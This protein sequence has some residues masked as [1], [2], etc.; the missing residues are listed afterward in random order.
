MLS[1]LIL[2][3]CTLQ[4]ANE[5]LVIVNPN[6][7]VRKGERDWPKISCMLDRFGFSFSSVITDYPGHAIEVVRKKIGQGYRKIMVVG[8]DGTLNE[9]INGI[10]SQSMVPSLAVTVAMITVGTGNDWAR[11]Y[12]IPRSYKHAIRTISR[13]KTFV[14]D[15]GKVSY[16]SRDG[17]VNRFFANLAGMGFDAQ[18]ARRT[19]MKK[20]KGKGGPMSYMINLF[21]SLLQYRSR[22]IT[23]DIDGSIIKA[24]VFSMNVGICKYNGGGMMQAPHAVADD[25]LL[26]LTIIRKVSKLKVIRSVKMLYDG[27]FVKLPEVSTHKGRLIKVSSEREILLEADG[28]TL[29]KGPFEFSIIPAAL[30]VVTGKTTEEA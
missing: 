8:G 14:Q 20:A 16:M 19:N 21:Q 26:A 6:A 11:M 22:D 18:V 15:V 17:K 13:G 3:R 4:L 23:I 10:F 24:S 27:S 12:N 7:G 28:E 1:L 29:G 30:R 25:G 9:V 2:K 5:W